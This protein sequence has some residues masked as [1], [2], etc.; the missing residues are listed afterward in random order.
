MALTLKTQRVKAE[1]LGDLKTAADG[2]NNRLLRPS[3]AEL[4]KKFPRNLQ[5]IYRWKALA[6]HNPNPCSKHPNSCYIL[7]I[8]QKH[9]HQPY[10]KSTYLAHYSSIFKTNYISMLNA[11]RSTCLWQEKGKKRESNFT[12]LELAVIEF[13]SLDAMELQIHSSMC[14]L[15][16]DARISNWK[17][18]NPAQ[19][20]NP[21][22]MFMHLLCSKLDWIPQTIRWFLLSDVPWSWLCKEIPE[23]CEEFWVLKRE[24]N[25]R[26]C[27]FSELN[28]SYEQNLLGFGFYIMC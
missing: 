24:K 21:I 26:E 15:K 8:E 11:T 20:Q 4:M 9:F 19:F 7:Q 12:Y 25:W 14:A 6:T 10:F 18:S 17:H 27:E 16:F 1:T 22:F 13:V 3:A 5:I 28:F 2:G 23:L